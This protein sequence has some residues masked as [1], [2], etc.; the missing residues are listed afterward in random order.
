MA[1]VT[2][3]ARPHGLQDPKA[4]IQHVEDITEDSHKLRDIETEALVVTEPKADFKLQPIILDEIRDDEVLVEMKY[5]GICHTDIVLQQGCGFQTGA[6]TVLNVLKPRKDDSLVVFG[7]GSV[8]LT[9]LMA[10]KHMGVGQIIAVDIVQEKLQM[11]K[12]L[13]AT[14]AINSREQSNVVEAIKA[15]SKTG[16]GATVAIDCTGVLRVIEDMVACLA[17][18][19]I[20]AVVGVPPPDAKIS[21][22]P[23]MFLLDNKKLVGV[24][25]GDSNPEDFIPQLIE[26]HQRGAFPIEKL[27]RTYPVENLEDAIHDLHAGN[28]LMDALYD[29]RSVLDRHN[30]LE[31]KALL[32][33]TDIFD[34]EDDISNFPLRYL[35][36][37]KK[38]A[39]LPP[40]IIKPIY[41]LRDHPE[42]MQAAMHARWNAS[43]N[44]SMPPAT[45]GPSSSTEAE[46]SSTSCRGVIGGKC[47]DAPSAEHDFP[48][49]NVTLAELAAFLPQSI[50]SW[51][52]ADRI[53]WNG[54]FTNDLKKIINK[55]RIMPYGPIENN[56]VY[57]M[58]SG[59]MRKRP[60][61]EHNYDGWAQ[62]SVGA[63]QDIAKPA[64]FD[65]NS[66]SVTGFRRPIVFTNGPEEAAPPI[67]FQDLANGVSSLPE[68]DDALDLTRCV[69]W[70]TEHPN[71]KYLYPTDYQ[72]VLHL[73]GGP[74][75][76]T[77]NHSD[78]AVL[79][80]LRSEENR[81]PRPRRVA[82]TPKTTR[83]T[84][85]STAVGTALKSVTYRD[86]SDSESEDIDTDDEVYQGP[87]RVKKR[88]GGP[89][90]SPRVKKETS[91]SDDSMDLDDE[92]YIIED[93]MKK[94]VF[95]NQDAGVDV[96]AED[97]MDIDA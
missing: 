14:D 30:Q 34:L 18:Q 35:C 61:E 23:L 67:P 50:K 76:P 80:R 71:E 42:R 81:T 10:A 28:I 74:M 7:L 93:G 2:T 79:G 40:D 55:Y 56:A 20:A 25:E 77:P 82:R 64:T 33:N 75:T 13:G 8:G 86:G 96:K 94:I 4:S 70:C 73:I 37:Y 1:T 31:A 3:T 65:A 95:R 69:K 32:H 89:R 83:T 15:R 9:A 12:E 47:R 38:N 39:V 68:G 66:I 5:S 19:G 59:Q 46:K 85:A 53:I 84:K 60:Y 49:A 6:G 22:D 88:K 91:Y 17:P 27:C 54:A 63:Q 16:A 51:D 26:L 62:W 11:A 43:R 45:S 90:R 24:I 29:E 57:R 52:V 92:E 97:D 48:D 21:I 87:K 36:V 58:M 41:Q 44:L 78:A 72:R